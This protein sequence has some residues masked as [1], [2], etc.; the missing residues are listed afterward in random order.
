MNVIFTPRARRAGAGTTRGTR[1]R[2][3]GCTSSPPPEYNFAD[4]P[5]VDAPRRVLA[6]QVHRGRRGPAGEAARGRRRRRSPTRAEPA[7]SRTASTCRRRRTGRSSS[8]SACR[9]WATASCSRTGGCSRSAS[10]VAFFG[11][12]GWAIEPST[13]PEPH[14]GGALMAQ[15]VVTARVGRGRRARRARGTARHEHRRQQRQARDLAVPRRRRPVLR[16]VHLDVL[17]VP[18]SRRAVPEGPDARRA[19]QHP[20]HVGDVVHPADELA[21]DGARARGDPARRPPAAA[22]LAARHRALRR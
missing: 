16:R 4:V 3:S 11:L 18:R 6:P 20:V 17:P 12:N 7:S 19:P 13:E 2:S 8:R 1:A 14:G 10:L 21:H 22:D 9:S 5:I 15:A